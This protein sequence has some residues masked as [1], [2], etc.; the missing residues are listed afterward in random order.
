MRLEI[1]VKRITGENETLEAS[2][3]VI[4]TTT[5]DVVQGTVDSATYIIGDALAL[6]QPQEEGDGGYP[7]RPNWSNVWYD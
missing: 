3:K 6:A 2:D 1:T 7:H 5:M 4:S